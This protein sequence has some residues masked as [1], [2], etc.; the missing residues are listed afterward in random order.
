MVSLLAV[1]FLSVSNV[2]ALSGPGVRLSHGQ[3]AFDTPLFV[4]TDRQ[5][6]ALTVSNPGDTEAGYRVTVVA[7]DSGALPIDPGW[8]I[9][10]PESFT[11]QPGESR[12]LQASLR[13]PD[14]ARLGHYE[15]LLAAQLVS[16]PSEGAS[17]GARLGAGAAA[18][19]N[20]DIKA[21]TLLESWIADAGEAW[22]E[23]GPV[24]RVLPIAVALGLIMT[25]LLRHFR[26]RIERR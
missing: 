20:F 13:I 24:G 8:V 16:T 17:V 3:I 18:R 6:P 23:M 15:G 14:N 25:Q 11:L 21:R 5:L 2:P 26:F 9:L 22:H 7:S 19:L 12:T 1:S 4:G 10:R